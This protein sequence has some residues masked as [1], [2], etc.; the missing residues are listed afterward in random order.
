MP[1]RRV[2]ETSGQRELAPREVFNGLRC[3]LRNGVPW[4]ATPNDPPPFAAVDRR[5]ARWLRAGG[6]EMSAHA[7]APE[8]PYV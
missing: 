3:V 4:R 8:C 7:A 2:P 1:S 5:A 6:F